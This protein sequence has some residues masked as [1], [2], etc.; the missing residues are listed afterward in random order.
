MHTCGLLR[1]PTSAAAHTAVIPV[2]PW[3]PLPW[4]LLCFCPLGP[5]ASLS[6]SQEEEEEG[7]AA[8]WPPIAIGCG[9]RGRAGQARQGRLHASDTFLY[10][11]MQFPI[12]AK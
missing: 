10:M 2:V 4:L 3:A 11:Y 7:A 5:L 12:E 8:L 6:P 1:L 9:C